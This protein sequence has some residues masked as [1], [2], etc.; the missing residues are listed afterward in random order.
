MRIMKQ[1][2]AV[3]FR[4][5]LIV[6]CAS[7][8]LCNICGSVVAESVYVQDLKGLSWTLTNGTYSKFVFRN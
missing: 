7:V 4:A 2:S 6:L 1:K 5:G 8:W 3:N